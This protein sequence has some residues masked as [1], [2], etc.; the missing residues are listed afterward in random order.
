MFHLAEPE[1]AGSGVT[2]L[3][4]D[5]TRS[6]NALI[7]SSKDLVNGDGKRTLK[8]LADAAQEARDA[9]REVKGMVASLQGPTSD[10]AAN[11]LPQVTAAVIQLQ[12]A[13]ESLER[14]TNEIQ[15]N[16][17]GTLGKSQAEDVKVKP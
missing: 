3:T 16:P 2:I 12:S 11:G 7:V 14:L 8:N 17:G 6:S 5:L 9:A 15:A 10:F 13:A 1:E 4:P